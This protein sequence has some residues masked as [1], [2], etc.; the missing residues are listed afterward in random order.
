[1]R[2]RPAVALRL[3]VF[4]LAAAALAACSRDVAAPTAPVTHAPV[5][6]SYYTYP[7][8]IYRS[9]VELGTPTDA[10]S[11]DDLI[12][13]KRQY[14]VSYNCAKGRP[15]WV[16]W[17][18]NKTHYGDAPRA[19]SFTSDGSLPTG[20]Y[21]VVTGDYTNSGYDRGH[22]VRSEERT[23]DVTDN[24]STFLMTNVVPQAPN[25]NQK[26][27]ERLERYCRE[28]ADGG[29]ELY[30][31]AGPHGQGGT[32]AD[33]KKLTV[34]KNAPFVTVP[35]SMWKVILVLD[36]GT[37]PAKSSRTIAVW[38]PNDQTV[39]LDWPNYRVSVAEVEKKTGL[40]FFPLVPADVAAAIKEKPDAVKVTVPK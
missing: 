39:T 10:N 16:S 23:W 14:T 29:K 5:A 15:N 22:Q 3:L 34:G 21:R 38:M 18:L 28:L 40:K 30:I 12:L 7:S 27:W 25:C 13:S 26:G 24:K 31:A 9:H 19:T 8:A 17:D 6:P 36:R 35:A 1:M 37:N 4:T 11:S 2:V 20:C 32:G 33:G